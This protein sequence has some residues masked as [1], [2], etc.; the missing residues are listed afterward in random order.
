M[1]LHR[2]KSSDA[3]VNM[4]FDTL[5]F[6]AASEK[7][8]AALRFYD[9]K[10]QIHTC[11]RFQKAEDFH[12]IL[13]AKTPVVARPTGGGLV[14]HE[15]SDITY[16]LIVPS[17]HNFFAIR[18]RDSYTA[19]HS[20]IAKV[21]KAFGFSPTLFESTPPQSS[22][23]AQCFTS[24]SYGDIVSADF[25]K[26]AGAAQKRT[27]KGFLLQGSIKIKNI[28]KPAF[29]NALA[30]SFAKLLDEEIQDSDDDFFESPQLAKR[31]LDF[32]ANFTK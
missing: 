13:S 6:D 4:A 30:T 12:A 17:K 5:L 29:R 21:M 3:S 23:P 28:D 31:L 19:I 22:N 26:F 2:H 14:F 9:W 18:P 32:Q 15:F 25:G 11:G 16:A 27:K 1:F 24:P 7:E 10:E 8:T 20:E